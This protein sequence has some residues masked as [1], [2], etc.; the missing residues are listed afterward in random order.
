MN[1]RENV[2]CAVKGE[3]TDYVPSGFWLHFP[4]EA[5]YGENAVKAHLQFF[6]ESETDIMK[7][8]NEHVVPHDEP[9]RRA[10][11]W[12][13]LKPF[14]KDAPFITAEIDL[15]KEIMDREKEPG[16]FLLTVHGIVASMWHARGGTAGYETG[17]SLLAQHL[18]EDPK[19]FSNGLKV[20][21]DALVTLT[22]KAIESGVDGIYYA[23]LG[24][25]KS[26]F[27]DDEFASFIAPCDKM[28]LKAAQGRTGCNIL[29][30]CKDNLNLSRYAGYPCDVVNWGIFEGNPSLQ[31]GKKLFGEKAILG[32][33][34]DRSGLLVDGS[35]EEIETYAR[36]LVA[37]MGHTKFILGA[38]C[39]LPTE[40][41]RER[42][43]WAVGAARKG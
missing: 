14:S 26:L 39:T 35:R 32:G 36:S 10:S 21:T 28:I 24:G 43:R 9:I 6:S 22:E 1:K 13:H 42:I 2:L 34:D 29:H 30:M 31:E 18:R 19:A 38:D 27:T 41:A 12:N 4:Q 33:F 3:R 23:A 15:M 8:M 16:L 40:I 7:I 5:A 37:Q 17:R 25:E 11:D 20:V